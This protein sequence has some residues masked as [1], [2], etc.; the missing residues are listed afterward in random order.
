MEF[1]AQ[2]LPNS[3]ETGKRPPSHSR[4][5][6]SNLEIV[7]CG[8]LQRPEA[9]RP[10]VQVHLAGADKVS[11]TLSTAWRVGASVAAYPL[12]NA[13]AGATGLVIHPMPRHAQAAT[14]QGCPTLRPR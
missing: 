4:K 3:L 12:K 2:D 14:H 6:F 9:A 13:D 5:L 8:G 10:A 1:S 7:G 11:L